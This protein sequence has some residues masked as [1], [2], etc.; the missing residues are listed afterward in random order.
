M[1]LKKLLFEE[2]NVI[3]RELTERTHVADMFTPRHMFSPPS[4]L[5]H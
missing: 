4:E 5:Q 3:S 2:T 1:V